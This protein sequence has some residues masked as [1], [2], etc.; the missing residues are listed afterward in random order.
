MLYVGYRCKISE[1]VLIS[2]CSPNSWNS[3]SRSLP[4]TSLTEIS[5][6][7]DGAP[8]EVLSHTSTAITTSRSTS[9]C[10]KY[11]TI[12]HRIIPRRCVQQLLLLLVCKLRVWSILYKS[13]HPLNRPNLVAVIQTLWSVHI[14]LG[15]AGSIPFGRSCSK[16][17]R[18][19]L[20]Q[21]LSTL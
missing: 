15:R 11:R 18:L 16:P 2:A 13:S 7:A 10:I 21:S 17:S 19:F 4:L 20:T 9:S 14:S 3:P 8:A 6:V 12:Q 1:A 5:R